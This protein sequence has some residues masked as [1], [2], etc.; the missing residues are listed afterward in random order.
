[1]S[2]GYRSR[3]GSLAFHPRKRAKRIYPSV[4]VFLPGEK[5]CLAGF[6][7]YKAGMTTVIATDNYDKSPSYGQQIT[8]PCT[9][10]ECPSL[11][12][13]GLRAYKKTPYGLIAFSEIYAEKLDKN[14]ERAVNIPK[15]KKDSLK[16][17][18]SGLADVSEI[19]GLLHTV[20]AKIG[21][22]K[23]PEVFEMPIL[24]K[25]QDAWNWG[26]ERL[27]KE[28]K[29]SEFFRDGD[30]I[31]IVA[32]TKGKGTQGPVKRFGIKIQ[33]R[34]CKRHRRH[35]G[36]IG[37]WNP[38]KT[39]WTVPMAGQMGFQ[40]RTEQN[41]RILKIGSGKEITRRPFQN[42]GIVADDCVLIKGSVAGPANR[43]IMIRKAIREQRKIPVPSIVKVGLE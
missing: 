33:I 1:M 7:G 41:K 6:A 24:G 23:T 29:I 21:L 17:I 4:K 18:E 35:P 39:M 32:I 30:F 37:Q 3:H 25:V 38:S 40:Q 15:K 36:T 26:K 31:N 42:Y 2:K 27:G 22:K 28:V 8:I 20:P 34:K 43:L 19:R 16:K 12:L 14:L 9:V 11:V 13:F 10:L 5:P